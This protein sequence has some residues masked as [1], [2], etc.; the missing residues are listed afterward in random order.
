MIDGFS[1][2]TGRGCRRLGE[3][4][5]AFGGGGSIDRNSGNGTNGNL[6]RLGTILGRV[7]VRGDCGV[8]RGSSVTRKHV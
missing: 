7:G 6:T 8:G 5:G 4:G 3:G 2:G 1:N